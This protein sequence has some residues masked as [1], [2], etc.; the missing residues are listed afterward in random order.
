VG[1]PCPP[2]LFCYGRYFFLLLSPQPLCRFLCFARAAEGFFLFPLSCFPSVFLRPHRSEPFALAVSFLRSWRSAPLSARLSNRGATP[3]C[4][5]HLLTVPN[6]LLPR[7]GLTNK[8]YVVT[9]TLSHKIRNLSRP[10]ALPS[11]LIVVIY[12]GTTNCL[13]DP[14]GSFFSPPLKKVCT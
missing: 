12:G 6:L 8:L 5:W 4:D 14:L 11:S 3:F 9:F 13:G 10:E 7:S 2:P 1:Q